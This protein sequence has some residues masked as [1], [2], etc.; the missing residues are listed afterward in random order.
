MNP[1]FLDYLIDEL[2]S[3]I[4]FLLSPGFKMGPMGVTLNGKSRTF[5]RMFGSLITSITILLFFVL[6][7]QVT[8]YR[9][10]ELYCKVFTACLPDGYQVFYNYSKSKNR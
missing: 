3:G 6:N 8:G 5:A 4:G 10:A 9:K 1:L 2:I 7:S